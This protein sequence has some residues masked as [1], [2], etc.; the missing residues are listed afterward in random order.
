M[1]QNK[2]G[3]LEDIFTQNGLKGEDVDV[4][5]QWYQKYTKNMFDRSEMDDIQDRLIQYFDMFKKYGKNPK[6]FIQVFRKRPAILLRE[7]KTLEHNLLENAKLL[8]LPSQSILD[9]V[10]K[11]P[12]FLLGDPQKHKNNA[13]TLADIFQTPIEKI[14]QIA[15]KQPQFLYH[16]PKEIEKKYQ[17]YQRC[18][19]TGLFTLKDDTSKDR[20]IMKKAY[21]EKNEAVLQ[22][23][24]ER[25]VQRLL[26]DP[27]LLF[28]GIDN[29]RIKMG[30]ARFLLAQKQTSTNKVFSASKTKIQDILE[31][32]PDS[33]KEKNKPTYRLFQSNNTK[34]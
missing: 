11:Q 21:H 19:Y 31:T 29:I 34:D 6:A 3:I 9:M 17:L 26:N 22:N 27:T 28:L 4:F 16:D 10:V 33:F 18:Y 20:A 32:A 12:T 5:T 25:L 24:T 7:P 1:Y 23:Y 13:D 14:I 30:Y 2:I 8:N 15:V